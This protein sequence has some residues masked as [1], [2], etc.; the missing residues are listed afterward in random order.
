MTAT[1]IISACTGEF[2]LPFVVSV[3]L[4]NSISR[5]VKSS[6]LL[7]VIYF[8]IGNFMD[9]FPRIFLYVTLGCSIGVTI[10]FAIVAYLCNKR[11][12]LPPL[13]KDLKVVS[14][15]SVIA[16]DGFDTIDLG[17]IND[18]DSGKASL[19]DGNGELNKGFDETDGSKNGNVNLNKN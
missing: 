13:P 6:V 12:F 14:P 11:L 8:Q 5:H 18:R 7:I 15:I 17:T 4:E 2:I 16:S 9:V 19:S 3:I 1:F 10:T